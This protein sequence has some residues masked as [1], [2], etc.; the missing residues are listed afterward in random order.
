MTRSATTQS[1]LDFSALV[2][3]EGA[4]QALLILAV[5]PRLKGLAFSAAAG[6]GKSTLAR[7]FKDLFLEDN[8]DQFPFVELPPSTDIENLLGGLDLEGTLRSGEIR[9]RSGLLARADGGAVYID[10]LN[11]LE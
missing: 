1:N 7:G 8:R 3:L 4:Q 9:M 5:E 10:G 6:T 2:G 11:L